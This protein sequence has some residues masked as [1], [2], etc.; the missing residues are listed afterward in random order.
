[1]DFTVQRLIQDMSAASPAGS[2]QQV[3]GQ[4]ADQHLLREI[5]RLRVLN[6][7]RE[8]GPLAR[9][10]IAEYTNLSRTTV[11]N[12]ID[13]LLQ[14]GF[15]R[16]GDLLN[17]APAGGR[18]AM[19]V[20]FN[21]DAGHILGM[22]VG[23]THLAMLLTNLEADIVARYTGPFEMKHGPEICLPRLIASVRAFV[24][25]SGIPW[26]HIAGIGLGIP[27][28]LD[29]Q[30][31]KL[32]NP[33]GMPEW[34]GVD[35]WQAMR[36]AFNVPIYLDNDANMGVLSESRYGAGVDSDYLAYV[37]VGTGI[38]VGLIFNNRIY[39][40]HGGSAGELG[41][42]T[43][44]EDGPLCYCANRGGLET[45]AGA[46]AIVEDAR[47]GLSLLAGEPG[48]GTVPAL[49][50]H[51]NTDISDVVQAARHGDAASIAALARAGEL[52]GVALAGLINLFNPSH[53]IIGGG[54]ARADEL[55]LASLRR[56]ASSRSLPAAWQGTRI[57]FG[58]LNDTAVA[59]GAA[60]LVIDAAFGVS[61]I[62]TSQG[63]NSRLPK[64]VQTFYRSRASARSQDTS[65][66]ATR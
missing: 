53:I 33:P 18:R 49:A 14:E 43:L 62:R 50:E 5:N 1:M 16:E 4:G 45:L 64:N 21:A 3:V 51:E 56:A 42:V 38:G 2:K 17:A 12:I 9:V 28:P 40:G 23:R 65:G 27:G 35:V 63:E 32:S 29:T 22:D 47:R 37:K 19:P 60:S 57:V 24:A 30:Q 31:H 20:H 25:D 34:D 26:E 36:Q 52:L 46:E 58:Q 10:R 13:S 48:R 11:S 7:V 61:T 39:R 54:V 8:A 41:H 55:L 59:L 66:P 15:V 44:D 6:C